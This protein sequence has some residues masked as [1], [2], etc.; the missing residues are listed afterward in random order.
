MGE[1]LP[2]R[3]QGR[4]R[5]L[6]NGCWQWIGA[7]SSEGYGRSKSEGKRVGVHRLVWRLLRGN[8]PPLLHHMCSDKACCNPEHLEPLKNH[9]EH[10][11]RH[12]GRPWTQRPR[13]PQEYCN[14][15]IHLMSETGV[16]WGGQ[17][18]C[19]I[20]RNNARKARRWKDLEAS[21]AKERSKQRKWREKNREKKR[22]CEREYYWKHRDKRLCTTRQK[23]DRSGKIGSLVPRKLDNSQDMIIEPPIAG[24]LVFQP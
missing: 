13:P 2:K 20:C 24:L 8:N 12:K 19:K 21:L 16:S 1:V 15:G 7:L 14:R 22:A 11:Q 23:K 5:V 10:A 9:K 17:R 18:Y 4:I 3:L 6:Q